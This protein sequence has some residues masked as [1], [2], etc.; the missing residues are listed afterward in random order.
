MKKWSL[1]I[2]TLFLSAGVIAGPVNENVAPTKN[3]ADLEK[4]PKS[5]FLIK[6]IKISPAVGEPQF[7]PAEA[8]L[9]TTIND[10]ALQNTKKFE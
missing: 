7:D 2:L 1:F 10:A 8:Q 4:T 3:K 6:K 5:L 9:R